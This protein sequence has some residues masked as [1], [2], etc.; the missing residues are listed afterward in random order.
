MIAEGLDSL[1]ENA[2]ELDVLFNPEKVYSLT[3]TE[4]IV[5][6]YLLL[7]EIIVGG[8]VIETNLK[9]TLDAY[10]LHSTLKAPTS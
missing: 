6:V 5:Q 4:L 3:L 10:K 9:E 1:F 7:D 2:S 8:T